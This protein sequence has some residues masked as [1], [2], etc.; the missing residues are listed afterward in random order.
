ML[1]GAVF[2]DIDKSLYGMYSWSRVDQLWNP[3]D[4]SK[5]NNVSQ[6][7]NELVP[8]LKETDK[9][10]TSFLAGIGLG[11]IN[12]EACTSKILAVDTLQRKL[13][14]YG[15]IFAYDVK[16]NNLGFM[17]LP[18]K[19]GD[20]VVAYKLYFDPSKAARAAQKV[21]NGS[22]EESDFFHF[23][24][25]EKEVASD[26]D[27]AVNHQAPQDPTRADIVYRLWDENDVENVRKAQQG[28]NTIQSL[29][30]KYYGPYACD[31]SMA[32]GK[33]SEFE[34]RY[35][36]IRDY[37]KFRGVF[38]NKPSLSEF[39]SN[40]LK[41][42]LMDSFI[43]VTDPTKVIHSELSDSDLSK[44]LDDAMQ[45]DNKPPSKDIADFGFLGSKVVEKNKDDKYKAGVGEQWI[46]NTINGF[47]NW[48]FGIFDMQDVV[49]LV[50][51][52]NPNDIEDIE[53]LT[54]GCDNGDCREGK[55][56]GIFDS[57]MFQT[58][59]IFYTATSNYA[60]LIF[61]M[62]VVLIG[63]YIAYYGGETRA[64][65]GAKDYIMALMIGIV[66]LIY[67]PYLWDFIF[68]INYT[69]TDGI[70]ALMLDHNIYM[71]KFLNMVW[72]NMGFA[73][74]TSNRAL[75]T[76]GIGLSS[77]M[78][79]ATLNY[80]YAMR[81]I[82]L[83]ILFSSFPL[84]CGASIFPK[85]RD[86]LNTWWTEVISNVFM[87][88]IHAVALGIFF[89]SIH[90]RSD[91]SIWIFLAYFLGM[92]SIVMM[93]RKILK[94]DS[95]HN[96]MGGALGGLGSL[97]GLGTLMSLANM[98]NG[99]K[100]SGR[101][102]Y[103][104]ALGSAMDG[105]L[106]PDSNN[107]VLSKIGGNGI[108]RGALSTAAGLGGAI[109]STALTGNPL[110]G[111]RLGQ[112]IGQSASNLLGSAGKG[113]D[114][115]FG[116]MNHQEGFF[117]GLEQNYMSGRGGLLNNAAVQLGWGA[118]SAMESLSG[119]QVGS[120]ATA[121]G[122]TIQTFSDQMRDASEAMRSLHPQQEAAKAEFNAQRSMFGQ[123]SAWYEQNKTFEPRALSSMA[124]PDLVNSTEHLK[125]AQ[126]EYAVAKR[127]GDEERIAEAE[128]NF[129]NAK[130][131][132][133]EMDGLYGKGSQ[134]FNDNT[135]WKMAEV[136]PTM[137]DSYV[138]AERHYNDVNAR[139]E[140]EKGRVQ[141]ARSVLNNR[142]QL[143]EQVNRFAGGES[144]NP[145]RGTWL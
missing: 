107:G 19:I 37:M 49:S 34:H 134:W 92:G 29:L 8:L 69:I 76:A 96:H 141:E 9:E 116:A 57:G 79:T 101:A 12:V 67:G 14:L 72:G 32:S 81:L 140:N 125:A 123:G 68:A 89:V 97:M 7:A 38:V 44:L 108:V 102:L 1:S 64:R 95:D 36:S 111:A 133:Q 50:Y 135:T 105:G 51:S 30:M 70:W 143:Y 131:G 45:E 88:A 121:R 138:Q 119:G 41:H 91:L 80:Q 73:D 65:I 54:K 82:F 48:I 106:I 53:K 127:S 10:C 77:A 63:F 3:N 58:I 109:A 137:P 87:D 90:Y 145:N 86:S 27:K 83:A 129:T 16:I 59:D 93:I 99:S 128:V 40:N 104:N 33:C 28:F 15:V 132:F 115:V 39:D 24:M 18:K 56:Y 46:A 94:L 144:T 5:K 120:S 126:A 6:I 122:G 23:A 60:P 35:S 61:V 25:D 136:A 142:T 21:A 98:A 17:Y 78:M 113:M 85:Y 118:Q 112:G 71:D 103:D 55:E 100:S 62:G 74:F 11:K 139:Y 43:Y 117:A 31:G 75:A 66:A 130:N 114:N 42:N 22:F 4:N 2:A 124:H 26:Y 13:L 84:V 110:M 20:T 52:K 47:T